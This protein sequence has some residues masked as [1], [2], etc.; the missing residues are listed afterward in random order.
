M[1][2]IKH[3]DENLQQMLDIGCQDVKDSDDF[4]I[5]IVG[6][7][8]A[9]KS[10]LSQQIA[11]YLSN[12]LQTPFTVDNIHFNTANYQ[13]F[14][15]TKPKYN[16]NILD[17]SRSSLNKM[18]GNSKSNVDFTNYI[19]ECRDAN[20]I[21]ILI[22][23]AFTDLDRYVAVHRSKL[24]INVIK[25]RDKTT[26]KLMRGS[27][28]I[29]KADNKYDLNKAWEMKYKGFSLNL[30]WKFGTFKNWSPINEKVYKDK[31]A[32]H[33]KEKYSSENQEIPNKKSFDKMKTQLENVKSFLK[34]NLGYKDIEIKHIL[35]K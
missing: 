29:I 10:V 12:Q 23:P 7:E 34:D 32:N 25:Y 19:S 8:G 2:E 3:I 22:L 15:L 21:H 17:E 16:I 14:A 31:K 5:I 1:Y 13:D 26:G 24:V 4:V 28:Q 6:S 27:Y 33:R 35:K 18:R 9:G 11:G 30:I 20:Q